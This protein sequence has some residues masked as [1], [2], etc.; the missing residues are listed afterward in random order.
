MNGDSLGKIV[1]QILLWGLVLSLLVFTAVRTLHFLGL[2]FPPDQGYMPWLGLAAFDGGVLLWLFFASSAASG[3]WQRAIAYLMIAVCLAGV[4]ICTV[5][6]MLLVS[7]QNGLVKLPAGTGDNALRGVIA[8]IIINV[9]AGVVVHLLSPAHLQ[10]MAMENAR[11]TIQQHAL[12]NIQGR[13]VEVAPDWG[14]KIGKQWQ[15]EM[16][17]QLLLTPPKKAISI[18]DYITKKKPIEAENE[19]IKK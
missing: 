16:F 7:A 14:E 19:P 15:D 2:T 10:K 6:D 13:A 18:T 1:A 5:A 9:I 17:S 12:K 8:V 3:F 4:I 11:S